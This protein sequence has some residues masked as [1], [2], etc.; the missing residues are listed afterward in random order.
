MSLY[1]QIQQ[2]VLVVADKQL[3]KVEVQMPNSE[4]SYKLYG[5]VKTRRN[6]L[7][8]LLGI[9]ASTSQEGI[10][11]KPMTSSSTYMWRVS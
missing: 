6:Q 2:S 7:N 1:E 3:Q 11:S 4:V 5:N 9:I 10:V 8:R